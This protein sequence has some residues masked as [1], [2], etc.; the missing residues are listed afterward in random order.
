MSE[1]GII[2]TNDKEKFEKA[3]K[4]VASESG[5]SPVRWRRFEKEKEKGKKLSFLD[6]ELRNLKTGEVY[7]VYDLP[8]SQL[9]TGTLDINAISSHMVKPD[10]DLTDPHIREVYYQKGLP[11]EKKLQT[12]DYK[13]YAK[14][15]DEIITEEFRSIVPE[16]DI[17]YVGGNK[18]DLAY[19]VLVK[20]G[21]KRRHLRKVLYGTVISNN[22]FKE[23]WCIPHIY[24][25]NGVKEDVV[26]VD[27]E[28]LKPK[29]VAFAFSKTY[30]TLEDMAESTT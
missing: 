22:A 26:P 13:K 8:E 1:I 7:F 6:F 16:T 29:S 2:K 18:K 19:D 23:G 14:S 20:N 24:W 17:G 3:M 25:W 11:L 21:G 5:L 27:L 30:L 15:V 12:G 28:D 9:K 10:L 4:T